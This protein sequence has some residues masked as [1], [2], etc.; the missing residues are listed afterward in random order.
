MPSRQMMTPFMLGSPKTHMKMQ[1]IQSLSGV[2]AVKGQEYYKDSNLLRLNQIVLDGSTLKV[3]TSGGIIHNITVTPMVI[4][5]IEFAGGA[6]KLIAND[7]YV[8][9]NDAS[10]EVR[11]LQLE[12]GN[13]LKVRKV[14]E[15]GIAKDLIAYYPLEGDARDYSGNGLHG[16]VVGAIVD[17]EGIRGKCYKFDGTSSHIAL[18]GQSYKVKDKITLSAWAYRDNWQDTTSERIISCAEN[19]GWQI[20][21]N[22]S[23]SVG[24]I[25]F[26]VYISGVGYKV[27]VYPISN[28]SQQGWHHIVG[29]FDGVEVKLYFDGFLVDSEVV[30]GNTIGYHLTNGVFIGAEATTH[31]TD[32][33]GNYWK[34]KI[35]DVRVYHKSLD[36]REIKILYNMTRPSPKPLQISKGGLVYIA[37]QLKEV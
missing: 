27:A 10:E 3:Y 19:G 32:P 30:G 31:P 21:F 24:S 11:R 15:V 17:D 16:N 8:T 29:T 23:S 13:G 4:D 33:T 25:N 9:P 2:E 5:R 36:D 35:Q 18:P 26:S 22:D 20:G 37:G 12:L 7:I 14:D 6:R 28:I 34:G 1:V